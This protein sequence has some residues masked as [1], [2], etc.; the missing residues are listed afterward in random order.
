MTKNPKIKISIYLYGKVGFFLFSYLY[1]G[2]NVILFSSCQV[3]YPLYRRLAPSI[4]SGRSR[5]KRERIFFFLKGKKKTYGTSRSRTGRIWSMNQWLAWRRC[6]CV[7]GI[8]TRLDDITYAS[9]YAL[10]PHV[11]TSLQRPVGLVARHISI[12][13]SIHLLYI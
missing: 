9:A 8:G 10:T 1:S 7:H 11:A 4:L 13:T 6:P 5:I 3:I 2:G 12:C